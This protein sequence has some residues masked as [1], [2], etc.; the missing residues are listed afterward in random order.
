MTLGIYFNP[1]SMD[2]A[3]MTKPSGGQHAE[4]LARL[5]STFHHIKEK[6]DERHQDD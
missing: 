2:A 1:A 6:R 5:V 3:N 4:R